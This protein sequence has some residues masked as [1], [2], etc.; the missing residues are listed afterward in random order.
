MSALVV[1]LESVPTAAALAAPYPAGERPH[2]KNYVKEEAIA[3]WRERDEAEWR[4]ERVK[5]CSLSPRLGRVVCIGWHHSQTNA[6]QVI[7]QQEDG[8]KAILEDFWF[9]VKS[10]DRLVTFNGHGF[11]VPFLII[12][13]L[14]NGVRPSVNVAP[15]LRRYQFSSHFDC[16]MALT[17]WN[18]Y[19]DG[20]LGDWCTA[21]GLPFTMDRSGDEIW[22]LYQEQKFDAIAAKCRA[23]VE[24]T[25][26]LYEKLLPIYG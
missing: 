20:T 26:S 24:A 23:D 19:G 16:R 5:Q 4:T 6:T 12:R 11:D 13:S 17:N 2:P 1:D 8:E 21:L 14:I 22:S 25:A 15:W 10:F 9:T 7:A 18:S 3:A